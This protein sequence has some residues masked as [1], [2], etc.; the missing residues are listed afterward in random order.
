MMQFLTSSSRWLL[1]ALAFFIAF[2]VALNNSVLALFLLAAL[3]A[4]APKVWGELKGNAVARAAAVLFALLLLGVA[5]GAT[6][7]SEAFDMLAKYDD[8]VMIPLFVLA[9]HED[10]TRRRVLRA[11][12]AGMIAIATISWLLGLHVIPMSDWVSQYVLSSTSGQDNPSVFHSHI[13]QGMLMAY[14]AYLFALYLREARDPRHV[15]LYMGLVLLTAGNV[16]IMIK[17][18]TGYVVLLALLAWFAWTALS[19]HFARRGRRLDWR[20][21]LLVLL[22]PVVLSAVAYV[23]VPRVH[24]RVQLSVTEFQNWSPHA[25]LPP[26]SIGDRLEFYYNSFAILMRE[27]LIGVGTGGF[28][29]AYVQQVAGTGIEATD[30][31]HD[32]YLLIAI[33]IG[34]VGLA[35]LLYLFVTEWRKAAALPGAF[36]RDAARGLVITLAVSCLF[37]SNLRDHVPGMFFALLSALWFANLSKAQRHG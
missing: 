1:V 23:A 12:L 14:T 32:E 13:T 21:S 24:E 29:A 6:P 11:F 22:F 20:H 18:R 15:A 27:P 19:S 10:V 33:Q 9:M 25:H 7:L 16:L 3:P 2:P 36:E 5:Y 30:N 4:Y 28:P 35:A 17:G 31:P 37:N 34:L 8:L 26:N